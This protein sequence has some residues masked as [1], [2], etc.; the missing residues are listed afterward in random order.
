MHSKKDRTGLFLTLTRV[1]RSYAKGGRQGVS[2]LFVWE[3]VAKPP[4]HSLTLVDQLTEEGAFVV[5]LLGA[6]YYRWD[7]LLVKLAATR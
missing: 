6:G 7:W 5:N 1:L 2:P 3:T 4:Q